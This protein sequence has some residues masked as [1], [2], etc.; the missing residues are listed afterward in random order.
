MKTFKHR[1]WNHICWTFQS[2]TGMNRI[3]LNGQLQGSFVINS[4]FTRKGIL[5]SDEVFQ[6]A[7]IIG[8]EPDPPSPNGGYEAEQVFV[9]DL[10]ELNMWNF[11]LDE[12]T[13]NLMG[14]CKSFMKGNIIAWNLENFVVY[15]VK[16]EDNDNLEDLCTSVDQLLVF[17]KKRSWSAAWTLCL[18]H[19]GNIHTPENEE[20][21]NQLSETLEP[22]KDKCADPVSG[23]LAWLGI[24]SKNYIWHKITNRKYLSVQKFTNW[25][26][27]APYY[28]SY[29]CGFTKVGGTW[30]SDL[31][32]NK[33][34]KLCTV[35]KISGEHKYEISQHQIIFN[36]FVRKSCAGVERLLF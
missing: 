7:F 24:N 14:N 3:Y 34:V 18:A 21:N 35:C 32:C 6:S 5:G 8:Q 20:E 9:G 23:N 2:L 17:P 10:T 16:I 30:D 27:T 36:F 13:I 19:G 25:A 26:V 15:K 31:N 1:S 11:T 22:Y 29:E 4:E 33:K 28:D 12:N